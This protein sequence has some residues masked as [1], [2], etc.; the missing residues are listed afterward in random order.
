MPDFLQNE[1]VQR[2]LKRS[3]LFWKFSREARFARWQKEARSAAWKT[4]EWDCPKLGI[5]PDGRAAAERLGFSPTE[6]FAHP[7]VL[8][9]RPEL[10]DYYRLL[11][12]L[13][14]KGLGQIRSKLGVRKKNFKAVEEFCLRLCVLLNRFMCNALERTASANREAL[15]RTMFAE[16]GSEW[17]GTWV[18][19][20]GELAAQE[21]E[22]LI[23]MFA[24]A[25]K[26]V[27][28]AK[29]EAAAD[30]GNFLILK[31]GA[32]IRFGSEPDVEFRNPKKELVCVIEIKGSADKAGAQTRLGETKKSF[33]KAKLQN[34]RCLTIFL[35]SVLTPA[36]E[37]QLRSERDIDKI[38]NL[39]EVCHDE[40]ERTRFLTEIFKF[41][42]REI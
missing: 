34:P 29:T 13:S 6:V 2:Y 33:T 3:A 40:A 16:A 9:E 42:L 5:T 32:S 41:I 25:N 12:C 30:E 11:A 8:Q 36:V 15:I 19:Q 23:V 17:Q 38:F 7:A 4:L 21:I 27:D 22:K 37:E 10:F 39:L 35:P 20:I 14:N 24:Q 31:S 28:E 1:L 18:N 26:L